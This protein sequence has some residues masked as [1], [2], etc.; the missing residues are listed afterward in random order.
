MLAKKVFR[1]YLSYVL[2][3]LSAKWGEELPSR[4]ELI[5]PTETYSEA[6]GMYMN[7]TP[8][9]TPLMGMIL[10]RGLLQTRSNLTDGVD[11]CFPPIWREAAALAIC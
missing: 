7:V 10:L 8:P 6:P 5:Q 2:P 4:R 1:G 9:S 11:P 3:D